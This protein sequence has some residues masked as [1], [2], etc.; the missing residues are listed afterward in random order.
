MR[1]FRNRLEYRFEGR[2][3]EQKTRH[4]PTY[5]PERF[6]VTGVGITHYG[7]LHSRVEARGKSQRNLELL[8]AE[9]ASP[10][11]SFNLGSEYQM[12]GDW[13]RAAVHFDEA[14]EALSRE[15]DWSGIGFA[16]LLALRGAR[17]R[18]ECGRLGEAKARLHEAI[19]LWPEYTD[20]VFE[21]A[22]CVRAEG[23]PAE[24]E[25]LFARCVELGDAGAR[26][27]ATVGAGS[28]I[29]LAVLGELAEA[30]GDD[31][32]AEDCYRR[33]LAAGP[34]FAAPVLPLAGLLLRRGL[35]PA[36]VVAELPL[37]R[38]RARLLAATAL[39][40][41]GH[42]EAAE[43][44]ARGEQGEAARVALLES[45]LA[46]RRYR[47]VLAE[48]AAGHHACFA[49]AVLGDAAAL[50][51][52][53]AGV[54][55]PEAELYRG[56]HAVLAGAAPQPLGAA[57]LEPALVALEALLRV[58]E[59]VAFEQLAAVYERIEVPP[60]VRRDRLAQV[61]L[62]QGFVD[63]A[64]DE[65]RS[66]EPSEAARLGLAQVALARDPGSHEARRLVK[67]IAAA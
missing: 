62:R 49:A 4:M 55:Q 35:D 23:D 56:W 41:A 5:L 10:F 39:L 63:S 12:L 33:S 58:Q 60:A 57:A 34:Q 2:I 54:E 18:R 53:L 32:A 22:V 48:T 27:A 37:D 11:A 45:L 8:A 21:L 44:L 67:E 3:H 61:Y 9:D 1:V 38:P 7:Y 52:A 13:E 16:P 47:E 14:W 59:F 29:A 42:A 6:E 26:Y 15:E 64:E 36:R 65:W 46:Q 28:F 30:R 20:L 50:A 31:A 19:A 51:T 25:R 43:P 17:A 66:G 24:A 40:E